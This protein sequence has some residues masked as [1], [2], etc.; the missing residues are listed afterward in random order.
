M[1]K[2]VLRR[3]LI[4]I[5]QLL[6]LSLLVFILAKMMPGDPFTG[7][8]NPNSDPKEIA[9]LRQEYGLNDPVWVQYTRWLG[10]MFH[11]DLG[12]SYIQKVPVTSLIWDRA[13]NTFWLSLMTVVLT[14]LIAIPLGVTA[15]RHQDE[16]QDHGVQIFNYITYA[17]PPFV[18]YIL[19]IWLFGFTLG[20]FPIS[21]SVSASATGFWGVLWS[22][23][24]H[25]ILP[26]I[27]YALITTTATVQYLRTGIVDNKVEDY[28]RTAR[29][30]GVPENVVFHKH[31]LRNS[32]LPIAAFF[33]NTITG[34]LSG[35]MVI[36][37]V[38]SY[39]GM[40]KLFLDFIGQR[41]YSTLTA[42]ILLFGIL[43]LVGNL[44]SDIIMSIIDPR[45]RIK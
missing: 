40:G 4:M 6:I 24:D 13:V 11:G 9:R 29:S 22:R 16:W 39:P 34:L 32:L 23:L 43:T 31:I 8:I 1:W 21:G 2:T 28:V 17:V 38:F 7:M 12:Q 30:K 41:D 25:M 5:P 35:S 3:I 27:L 14:Y 26:A 45:I 18:F 19:G 36:E 42:L 44:L 15:G 37:S 20:W 10:N 33:G